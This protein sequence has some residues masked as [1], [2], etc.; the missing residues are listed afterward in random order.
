MTPDQDH[1]S[2][3]SILRLLEENKQLLIET[4]ERVK[5]LEHRANLGL[6]LR[7]VWLVLLFALPFAVYVIVERF[8]G[9]A[10]SAVDERV[11]AAVETG[12]NLRAVLDIY[13]G[14]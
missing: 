1:S 3:E 5:K 10:V 14:Q 4:S 11:D 9:G 12:D 7:I 2:H 8:I 13:R 6:A